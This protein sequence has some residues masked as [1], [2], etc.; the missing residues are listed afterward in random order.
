MQPVVRGAGGDDDDRLVRVVLDRDLAVGQRACDVEQ[1]PAGDDDGAFV[2]D[3]R[4]ERRAQRH[5]HVGRCEVKLARFGAQLD[6][7]ENEHGRS[8]RDTS[9]DDRELGRELVLREP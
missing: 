4:V 6:A 3:L 5:L 2:A 9:R 8:R 1:Q 7:A